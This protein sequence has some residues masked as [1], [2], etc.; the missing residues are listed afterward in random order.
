MNNYSKQREEILEVTKENKMHPTAEEIYQ[1]VIRKNPKISKST[2]YRNINILLEQGIIQKITMSVG[3]DRYDYIH[4]MHYHA[5]CEVCG[6][7]FDFQYPFPVK[8]MENHIQKQNKQQIEITGITLYGICE[9]CKLKKK[10][11]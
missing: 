3:P 2:V 7:V 6:K 1:L 5:I 11:E 10:E 9:V 4:Q 8:E